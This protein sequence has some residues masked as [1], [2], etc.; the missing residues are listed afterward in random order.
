MTVAA[1]P[2][3]SPEWKNIFGVC[4]CIAEDFGFNALWLRLVFAVALLWNP[5]AVI[6]AY[7]VLGVIVLVSRLIA[8]DRRRAARG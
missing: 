8:P 5:T 4:A 3:A 1:A 6:A 7:A 2:A